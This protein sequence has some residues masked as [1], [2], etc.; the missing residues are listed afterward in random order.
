MHRLHLARQGVK[1]LDA[2]PCGHITEP[3]RD[4]RRPAGS[5]LG[6]LRLSGEVIYRLK[7][8][9][10]ERHFLSM[11]QVDLQTKHD[12]CD[13][14]YARTI[15]IPANVAL[16]G[17]IHATEN[18]LLVRSGEIA[19]WVDAT[20]AIT[21][22]AGDMITSKAGH[23]RIG[24]AITD[25]VLTTFHANPYNLTD[26]EE[27]WEYYTLSGYEQLENTYNLALGLKE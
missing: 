19:I 13:G 12:F 22:S 4:R 6:S 2:P 3:C 17:A 1:S 14:V 15:T 11:P 27:L 21:F 23:K 16:T 26:P 25:T 9:E 7:V 18:F 24:L 5:P 10:L 20:K 8:D